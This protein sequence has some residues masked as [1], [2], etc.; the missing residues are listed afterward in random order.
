MV[1]L[2]SALGKAW[3]FLGMSLV[4]LEP[5][6]GILQ[7]MDVPLED[8]KPKKNDNV[9]L[10]PREETGPWGSGIGDEE[11]RSTMDGPVGPESRQEGHESTEE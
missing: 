3:L 2:P 8:T 7:P 10:R 4:L 9:S 6:G 1:C 5:M 11:E